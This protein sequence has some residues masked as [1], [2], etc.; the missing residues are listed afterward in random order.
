MTHDEP[1]SAP[2]PFIRL[3]RLF[4]DRTF[5]GGDESGAGELDLSLGLVLSLLALPG[6]LYSTLLFEK[7]STLLLWMRGQHNFDPVAATVPD[8]Y[9][10]IVLS[11][12]VTGAVAVW[13]WDSIFPDRRD[14]VN[15]V[16]LPISTKVIFLANL[17]A[18]LCLAG[19]LAV[20]VN[21][22]SALL[23]PLAAS[24]GQETFRYV[25]QIA[26]MHVLTVLL[27]SV[28]SF[29]A[30]F[31]T[32]GVLMAAL[33]YI[34]FR[35]IS[36]YLRSLIIVAL[37]SLLSTSFAVPSMIGNLP[38]TWIRFLPTVW[39]LG[40]S[41]L[42]HGSA[43][44]ALA[45]LG[46]LSWKGLGFLFFTAL[47]GYSMSY[48]T[49]FARIPEAAAVI[50][51]VRRES[52]SW[53]FPLFDRM[54]LRTP[55]ERAGYRYAIKTLFR[56]EHHSLV[57]AGFSAL[58]IVIASQVLFAALSGGELNVGGFPSAEVLS[59]PLILAYSILL[60]LRL[61]FEIPV[62]LQANWIF[63]LLAVKRSSECIP[64][65]RK[66]MLTFVIPWLVAFA[67][68][69]YAYLWGWAIAGFH[70]LIVTL[71]SLVLAQI[72][73][74]GYRKVPFTC[75]YPPFRDSAIVTVL[76]CVLGYFVFV[77]FI[78]ELECR[79]LLN[80]LYVVP[81]ILIG[82]AAWYVTSVFGETIADV[83]KQIIFDDSTPAPF[84]LL[85]LE[86]RS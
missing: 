20:D 68:P 59:V 54:L 84:E 25:A 14:Y 45:K 40:L 32:V 51:G 28:F 18:I 86:Q 15:L 83:D 69:I 22:A 74:V 79:A 42:L 12:V 11:T 61:A 72:L 10:F 57:V 85:D 16:P 39:F 55:F 50:S 41:Q 49:Y 53:L 65:V 36:I 64:L 9:F 66:I 76:S 8:E 34:V 56:S 26:G 30:V 33:P 81:L 71:L 52:V 35:R 44:P 43:N 47:A 37:V 27:A 46:S 29:L 77:V 19:V 62:D 24:S 58:A 82:P 48:R 73:L 23:Y 1:Q 60:G 13:R 17:T 21:A 5:H 67:T 31:A 38:Q 75:S 7:Y 6:A 78:S 80:P 3:V 4:L 63:R 70:V 2:R